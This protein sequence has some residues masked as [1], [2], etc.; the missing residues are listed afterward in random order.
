MNGTL[1]V[2]QAVNDLTYVAYALLRHGA[3][4]RVSNDEGNTALHFASRH[5]DPSFIQELLDQVGDVNRQ[6][7]ERDTD[8]VNE[9]G[10][11]PLHEACMSGS[12]EIVHTL[13]DAENAIQHPDT[14]TIAGAVSV[15]LNTVHDK[16]G[17]DQDEVIVS[18]VIEYVTEREDFVFQKPRT[19]G[20]EEKDEDKK[21]KHFTLPAARNL[22]DI[23]FGARLLPALYQELAVPLVTHTF[24]M[25]RVM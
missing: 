25:G 20:L 8:G 10:N 4:V 19:A 5:S 6:T 21:I 1:T 24:S 7:D 15:D 23:I 3:D 17:L 2:V 18:P 16:L 12:T 22:T 9:K 11:T 13:L 14:V